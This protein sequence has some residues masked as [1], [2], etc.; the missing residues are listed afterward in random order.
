MAAD[1]RVISMHSLVVVPGYA[2]EKAVPVLDRGDAIKGSRLDVLLPTFDQAKNWGS[3]MLEVKI[4]VP[5][6]R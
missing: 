5:V 3:R 1:T 6:E 2:G 4:F